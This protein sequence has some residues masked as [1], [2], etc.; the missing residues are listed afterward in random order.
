MTPSISTLDPDTI[1]RPVR[2]VIVD[3]HAAYRALVGTV[4]DAA[5][6]FELVGT[7]ASLAEIRALFGHF[8][9]GQ[10][11]PDLVL[12]DVHLGEENGLD[13]S[14]WLKERSPSTQVVLISTMARDELPPGASDCGARG[15]VPKAKVSPSALAEAWAGTF[16]W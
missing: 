1:A 12:L 10:A 4:V 15:F 16:D 14:R 3:D 2:V 5:D 8:G 9:E 6:G 7:A 13:I 11:A